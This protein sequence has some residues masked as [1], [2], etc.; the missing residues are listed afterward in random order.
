MPVIFILKNRIILLQLCL[1]FNKLAPSEWM[2]V[3][4]NIVVIDGKEGMRGTGRRSER[5]TLVRLS[6]GL[7][8]QNVFLLR[9]DWPQKRAS[10]YTSSGSL[11]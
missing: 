1:A 6:L 7:Q 11:L 2:K 10:E 5:M 3:E 9:N 8:R 4:K